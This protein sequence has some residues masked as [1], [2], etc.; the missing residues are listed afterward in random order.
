MESPGGVVRARI[1]NDG[2]VSVD[3]GVPNFDP[4]LAAHVAGSEEAAVYALDVDG[5][6]LSI[7]APCPWATRTWCS[8]SRT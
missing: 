2:L 8:P 4:A 5:I 7:S 6:A 1:R 3:M